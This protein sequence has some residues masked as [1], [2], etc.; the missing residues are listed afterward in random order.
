MFA[1][2]QI[3]DAGEKDLLRAVDGG[4]NK[5]CEVRDVQ[6][7]N[8]WQERDAATKNAISADENS[9]DVS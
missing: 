2:K 1:P 3:D 9:A 6:I 8:T 4:A 5:L 7:G